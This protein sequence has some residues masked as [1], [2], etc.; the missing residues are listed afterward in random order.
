MSLV[1]KHFSQAEQARGVQELQRRDE[2]KLPST[3][4]V[5]SRQD[6]TPYLEPGWSSI[7]T[8]PDNASA[9]FYKD[10]DRVYVFGGLI[11]DASVPGVDHSLLATMPTG[12]RPAVQVESVNIFTFSNGT[13]TDTINKYWE[14]FVLTDGRLLLDQNP[15]VVGDP[16]WSGYPPDD[17]WLRMDFSYRLG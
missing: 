14:C 9:Y 2:T 5:E 17:T 10:R 4:A 16:G 11:L 7:G 6:L 15:D 12:Y 1:G 13:T 8:F 3:D